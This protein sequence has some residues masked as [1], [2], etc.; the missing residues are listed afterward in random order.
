MYFVTSDFKIM[1]VIIDKF[2]YL[3]DKKK[4][5]APCFSMISKVAFLQ[6]YA[7]RSIVGH[8]QLKFT[9]NGRD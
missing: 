6:N 4:I 7:L 2:I 1:F 3:S 8:L 9:R 5:F